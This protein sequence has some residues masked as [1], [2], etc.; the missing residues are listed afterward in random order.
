MEALFWRLGDM[1][2]FGNLF[3][4]WLLLALALT[5]VAGDLGQVPHPAH[6]SVS[7]PGKG[8][9]FLPHFAHKNQW[10]G[11]IRLVG[12]DA[13]PS[14]PAMLPRCSWVR[15][16]GAHL[17]HHWAYP[18]PEAGAMVTIFSWVLWE[19]SGKSQGQD[20]SSVVLGCCSALFCGCL[21]ISAQRQFSLNLHSNVWTVFPHQRST[22]LCSFSSHLMTS[23]FSMI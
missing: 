1:D 17:L 5:Q 2:T 23:Y 19:E 16:K 21:D 7:S 15:F 13:P 12:W 22:Y 4:L 3:F 9:W 11:E 8:E 18:G 20:P 6:L 14:F 10:S